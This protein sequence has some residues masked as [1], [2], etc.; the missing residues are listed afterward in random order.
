MPTQSGATVLHAACDTNFTSTMK[1]KTLLAAIAIVALPVALYCWAFGVPGV[2]RGENGAQGQPDAV[3]TILSPHWEGI[4]TEFGR[5][6]AEWHER[7]RGQRVRV[8]WLNIGGTSKC[9]RYVKSEFSRRPEGIDVDLFFGGGVDPFIELKAAKQ[10]VPYRLPDALLAKL[11]TRAAGQPLYDPEF[12]WYGTALAGFGIVYNKVV[13]ERMHLPTPASWADLADPKLYQW[14]EAGDLRKSGA[15]HMV[16]EII[17]QACGWEQGLSIITR[18]G[19]NCRRITDSGSDVPKDVAVG[20][21]ACG[22]CIDFYAWAQVARAGADK[23]GFVLPEGQTI[24]NPDSIAILK[25]A[26]QLEL[27]KEFIRFTL[28]H[29]GQKLWM[30]PKGEAGGPVEFTLGRM[31]V[32]PSVYEALA[33]GGAVQIN[34]FQWESDLEYDSKRG[35]MRWGVLN[36]LVGALMIETHGELK[37]A[38]RAIIDAGMPEPAIKKLTELPVTEAE[39]MALAKRWK[40]QQLRNDKIREW[41]EFGRAKYRA[42]RDMARGGG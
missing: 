31:S 39:I 29:A 37:E 11:P 27:A 2:E 32:I 36:D 40:D 7:E 33:G 19:G 6:F 5:A 14:V 35:G 26:P 20:E 34:P 9:V 15:A 12:H 22:M 25:G 10:S 1:P 42:A 21:V 18:M 30:L 38:W 13:C 28:S 41:I 3:L 4:R 16:Y 24:V 8:E 17:L 23:I